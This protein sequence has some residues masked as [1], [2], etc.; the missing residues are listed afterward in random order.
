MKQGARNLSGLRLRL[1]ILNSKM[2]Q[3]FRTTKAQAAAF[4]IL[5]L[6]ACVNAQNTVN[7]TIDSGG[8]DFCIAASNLTNYACPGD[9]LEIDGTNDYELYLLNYQSGMPEPSPRFSYF[10]EWS[11]EALGYWVRE[12]FY[13]GA[14]FLTMG[15]MIAIVFV[16]AGVILNNY[17]AQAKSGGLER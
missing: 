17:H 12:P 11:T 4:A 3:G 8:F 2:S 1:I 7:L 5:F 14:I 13:V 15:M 10:S 9:V 16:F 6:A